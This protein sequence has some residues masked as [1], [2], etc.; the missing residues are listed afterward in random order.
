MMGKRV[1]QCLFPSESIMLSM[2][3]LIWNWT[4]KTKK[5]ENHRFMLFT[6]GEDLFAESSKLLSHLFLL[7]AW[8]KKTLCKALLSLCKCNEIKAMLPHM[9][10]KTHHKHH[11]YNDKIQYLNGIYRH[12]W[13]HTWQVKR[14][15]MCIDSYTQTHVFVCI[16]T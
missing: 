16:H 1:K 10:Q 13:T 14:F 2:I 11:K 8:K 4:I 9:V 6:L 15:N 3:S 7:P 12:T 5:E